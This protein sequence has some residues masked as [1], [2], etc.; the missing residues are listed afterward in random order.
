M[1]GIDRIL[2]P[3]RK[4]DLTFDKILLY[5]PKI[6]SEFEKNSR[7]IKDDY[8]KYRLNQAILHKT[9]SH[10]DT[11]INNKVLVPH[12]TAMVDFKTGYAMGN[13]IQY[14]QS[15]ST[16]TDDIQY[17]NK[18]ANS[19][20]K[21]AIDK[22]V[23]TWVYAT[24]VGYYFIEPKKHAVDIKKEAPF[25]L[26]QINSD[27]CCK[28]YSSFI[29]EEPLFDML[30]THVDGIDQGAPVMKHI[31]DIYTADYFYELETVIGGA[32]FQ[33][34]RMEERMVY[35]E[36]PLVEK[37][38]NEAGIGIVSLVNSMQDAI[39]QIYSDQI[40]NIDEFVNQ[41]FIYKN[42][43]LGDNPEE[44][45]EKH[46]LMRKNGAIM[47]FSNGQFEPDLS[48]LDTKLD[49]S[50]TGVLAD[51][52]MQVMYDV[53]GVP[54]ASS[55]VTSGGDTGVSRSLG[56]GWE[57]AYIRF[58]GEKPTLLAGDR[59][60]LEKMLFICQNTPNN[61]VNDLSA[62]EIDIKYTPNM[63][64]NMLVKSQSWVNYIENGCPPALAFQ[65][66]N[67]TSDP[68]TAGK[69]VEEY[70]RVLDEQAAQQAAQQAQTVKPQVDI[71]EG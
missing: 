23:G 14:A 30:V 47:L 45:A 31:I 63:T 17:L 27:R 48:T 2:V 71:N 41:L 69:M 50:D 4:E 49:F 18:Y 43:S 52:I 3:I 62:S 68:V 6:Y 13:A 58:L 36:L 21:M 38:A 20:N 40:D 70:K 59:E 55:S 67:N 46:R 56:N 53:A 7:K 22:S 37:R 44:A 19:V 39:N 66:V 9:R 42:V 35:K 29:G 11:E 51:S 33:L 16:D 8:D 25:V 15:K 32:Q 5:M 28:V 54:L 60:L 64:D 26:Y 65:L 12:L 34:I 10:A 24:G 57:N 61:P 1:A